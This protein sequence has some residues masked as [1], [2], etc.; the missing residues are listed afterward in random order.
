MRTINGC[1]NGNF[2]CEGQFCPTTCLC[3]NQCSYEKCLLYEKP[4][5][6][7]KGTNGAW[8]WD[9][10]NMYWV[11]QAKM[12]NFQRFKKLSSFKLRL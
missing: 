10:W 1:P 9:K 4:D 6:C 8:S 3:E 11:A 7:L 5:D 2:G 12:G